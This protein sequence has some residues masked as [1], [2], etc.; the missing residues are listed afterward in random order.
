MSTTMPIISLDWRYHFLGIGGIGMSAL[1]MEL[2]RRGVH[3]SGSDIEP[4]SV[5]ESLRAAGISTQIGH[6]GDLFSNANAVVF[7]SALK[8]DNPIW[9]EVKK[10]GILKFHRSEMM[11]ALTQ[12]RRLLAVTGTHGKTTSTAALACSLE[13]CEQDPLVFL[14][15]NLSKWSGNF[16]SGEGP[17]CVCEADESDGSFLKLSP[18]AI[19]LTNI[20]ADHLDIHGSMETLE[21]VMQDFIKRLPADGI[22]VYNLDDPRV[23]AL[24]ERMPA[25]KSVSFG[26]D[27]RADVC[28]QWQSLGIDGTELRLKLATGE[29]QFRSTLRGQY[30]ALNLAGAF[31]LANSMQLPIDKIIEGLEKFSGVDRRQQQL[32]KLGNLVLMD[33]YA[34]YPTEIQKT[35]ASLKGLYPGPLVVA[36]QPHLY[37]RTKHFAKE[38]AQ[39]LNLAD[40]V[41]LT[42]IYSAREQPLP[43]VSAANI[44]HWMKHKP[45]LLSHWKDLI[46]P[47]LNNRWSE[48]LFITMGAGDITKLW[49]RVLAETSSP[50]ST[51]TTSTATTSTAT[52][53]TATPPTATKEEPTWGVSLRDVLSDSTICWHEPLA[54]KNSL[55]IGGKALCLVDVNSQS[56]L[57]ALMGWLG[58]TEVPWWVLGK[59]SNLLIKDEG[60][61]GVVIRLGRGMQTLSVKGNRVRVGAGLANA[62]FVEKCRA[63]NLGGMEFL[64]VIPGSIGGA[65]KMNAGAHGGEIAKFLSRV[66]LCLP[67]GKI[68][69]WQAN[70]PKLKTKNGGRFSYRSSPFSSSSVIYAAEFELLSTTPTKAKQQ[71]QEMLAWRKKHH[72][73]GANCGSVFKN[74]TGDTAAQ[75]IDRAGLKG[76]TIGG[77]KVSTQHSN[78]IINVNKSSASDVLNLIKKVQQEVLNHSGIQLE[79]EVQVLP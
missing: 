52:T 51:A 28:L 62:A 64:S 14:G 22:L 16:R 40:E 60:L 63:V 71:Q 20:E 25:T 76:L 2:H 32:G 24:A 49:H 77:A 72:P 10:L 47:L 53:S 78:F 7:S 43:N 13:S 31:A 61:A 59:G 27:K 33:D 11:A 54:S 30:N 26:M 46:P 12:G 3:V 55:R 6:R 34:H 35:L 5:L 79:T 18:Q 39:A 41:L 65:V 74:P 73:R 19:L 75:L 44:A 15:G 66:W 38:F 23:K 70:E 42:P 1:A 17:F 4:S 69:E 67:R 45:Q 68:Q 29:H 37:S 50:P 58:R 57:Q 56:D 48:G 21:A 9:Q 36:F 8:A